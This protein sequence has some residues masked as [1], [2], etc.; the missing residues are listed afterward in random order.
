[1]PPYAHFLKN[2]EFLEQILR[3]VGLVRLDGALAKDIIQWLSPEVIM[4]F[5]SILIY[6]LAN[7]FSRRTST[8]ESTTEQGDMQQ[9]KPKKKRY[10]IIT[11]IGECFSNGLVNKTCTVFIFYLHTKNYTQKLM[12]RKQVLY[13]YVLRKVLPK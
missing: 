2:C 12:S 3:H 8:E 4:L 6:L 9:P 7:K 10:G 1:M 11:V 5:S 13:I